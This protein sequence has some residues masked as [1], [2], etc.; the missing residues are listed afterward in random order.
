MSL[1]NHHC[2]FTPGNF[3]AVPKTVYLA[4]IEGLITKRSRF[5]LLVRVIAVSQI[6]FQIFA[7]RFRMIKLEKTVFQIHFHVFALRFRVRQLE[8]TVSQIHV[9]VFAFVIVFCILSFVGFFP[10]V[11]CQS[12]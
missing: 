1:Q 3:C 11:Q 9:H 7:S 10:E 6:R 2:N 5:A 12:N 8:K 4:P